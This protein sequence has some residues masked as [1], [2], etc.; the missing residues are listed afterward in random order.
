MPHSILSETR[1]V[2]V[3]VI[4][5]QRRHGGL[6]CLFNYYIT[7]RAMLAYLYRIGKA[8]CLLRVTFSN[9]WWNCCFSVFLDSHIFRNKKRSQIVGLRQ[10][11]R[12]TN[13]SVGKHNA[14]L[15]FGGNCSYR[16]H[17]MARSLGDSWRIE[18]CTDWKLHPWLPKIASIFNTV[19]PVSTT[20]ISHSKFDLK[21]DPVLRV[22]VNQG[23]H[24]WHQSNCRPHIPIRL[25]C[26]Q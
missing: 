18:V 26:A 17:H 2:C 7:V 13:F 6:S 16:V 22:T 9:R 12:W 5:V 14:N 25:L 19:F 4:I 11:M 21:F 3:N 10:P 20:V 8:A 15:L 23:S 1:S 24:E